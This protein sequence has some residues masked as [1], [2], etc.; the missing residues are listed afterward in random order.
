LGNLF[1]NMTIVQ[2]ASTITIAAYH[3]CDSDPP[4]QSEAQFNRREWRRVSPVTLRARHAH[5]L[6]DE[7]EII[8]A[9]QR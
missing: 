5:M 3:R 2:D 4:T 1:T 8:G 6:W 7:A 9:L